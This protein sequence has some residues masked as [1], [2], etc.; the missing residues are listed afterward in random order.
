LQVIRKETNLND[1]FKNKLRSTSLVRIDSVCLPL[2][3]RGVS[4]DYE[5][6]TFTILG[7]LITGLIGL[8]IEQWRERIRLRRHFRDV[9]HKYLKPTL[10]EL[11]RLRIYFEFESGPKWSSSNI[12]QL[13]TPSP[14]RDRGNGPET[15]FW[16]KSQKQGDVVPNIPA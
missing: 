16:I 4:M 11:Y 15:R 3:V 14:E 9:K 6:I 13:L 10:E 12:P 7:G 1:R 2:V 8:L 5:N